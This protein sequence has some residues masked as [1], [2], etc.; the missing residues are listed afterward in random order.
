[1]KGRT[2]VLFT[3]HKL[4]RETYA[5][6]NPSLARIGIETLAQGIHGERSTLLE[7]FRRNPKSV[8]LGANSFWEGIDLPGDT[9]SCVI[10]VKLPF[11][12][13]TL[14]LI[15]ARSEFLK[16]QGRDPFQELFLPEAVIRFKQGFGRLIRSKG[17]RGVV[18]L[19]DD[20]AI[21]KY[22]GR[23]FLSSLPIQTHVR[24]ENTLVL[25]KIEE[26]NTR[27]LD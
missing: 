16:S 23:V 13:P 15:E 26:W 27:E 1:M 9:L 11:W 21:E 5:S 20:R 17:D 12:P 3:A 6:L 14:P 8:L 4:L 7:A 2:L 24:G 25:R 19:L 10:L 22:Y 18:I